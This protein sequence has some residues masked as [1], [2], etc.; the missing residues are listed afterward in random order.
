MLYPLW[1]AKP[2][3]GCSTTAVALA[4]QLSGHERAEVLL[5]DL[6]GDLAA[7]LG[8][9]DATAGVTDWLAAGDATDEALR[10]V[11]VPVGAA[12]K[13]LP[14][15]SDHSWRADR[16]EVLV[17]LLDHESRP[18]VIDIG[19]V[20]QGHGSPMD[21]LRLRLA[22]RR[23]SLLV[24]RPCY[25][26]MRRAVALPMRP[27]G[28][29]LIRERGRSLDAFDVADILGVSIAAQIDHDPAVARALDAG[30]LVRRCPRLLANQVRGVIR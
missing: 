11:E 23:H 9:N 27:G 28:I 6:G 7:A 16:A 25:L 5:V 18:V 4:T 3:S 1:T 14:R 12:I 24:T 2:G 15:G 29:I 26:A 22:E 19:T 30:L 20:G 13:L 17:R 8:V 10:R 21:Q